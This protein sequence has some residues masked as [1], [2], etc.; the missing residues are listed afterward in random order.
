MKFVTRAMKKVAATL[1]AI[2]T[3]ATVMVAGQ[4]VAQAGPR[5]WLRPDA[6]GHCDWDAVGFWVQRCDV[7]SPAMNRNIQVQIQPAQ[8]GGNAGFYLLD[9]A[10]AT[11]VANAWTVDANAPASYVNH[12]ITLV[13]PVG[14]AGSFYADWL[15][16]A[17]YD[18]SGP[19]FKW[20]TFL[21]QELPAYLEAHFGVSRTNN[22]IAGL[23]M[24]GTA[25]LN[26]AARNPAQFRQAMSWS[27]YLAMTLP[28]MEMMLRLA[29]WD[30]GRL[31]INAMYGAFFNPQRFEN[32]PMWNLTG[33]Q[34]KDV[35]ISAASGFWS[36]DDIA[37]YPLNQRITGSVLEAFS[38]YT[39]TLWE[40]KARTQGVKVTVDY[41]PA[42]I[43]NWHQWR[44]QLERTKPRVLDVMNAW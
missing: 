3:A 30:V 34:G 6:T 24:G 25:A 41:P 22:S 35:Y 12:N 16:P 9:G 15:A 43:H 37:H 4:G 20:E 19:H 13:M 17:S 33:L 21:T 2:A 11:E 29:M 36:A 38:L 10:R 14:G 27:G 42:G 31:N 7:F 1:T 40:L 39:S 23:S 26:L 32:D 44:Y 8:R 28:G 18:N 5:D